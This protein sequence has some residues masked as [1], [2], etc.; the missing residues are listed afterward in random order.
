M[1]LGSEVLTKRGRRPR[2][3]PPKLF[4]PPSATLASVVAV[5]WRGLTGDEGPALDYEAP[6]DAVL[7]LIARR[8]EV[9]LAE[10]DLEEPPD[11]R[12][13]GRR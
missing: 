10:L 4:S 11:E 13:E 2:P 9:T 7:S 3:R 8:V 6:L 1:R 5:T 12:S